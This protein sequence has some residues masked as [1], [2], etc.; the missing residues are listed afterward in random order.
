MTGILIDDIKYIFITY[1]K[2]L[3]SKSLEDN[4][5]FTLRDIFWNGNFNDSCCANHFI[6]LLTN[7]IYFEEQDENFNYSSLLYEYNSDYTQNLYNWLTSLTGYN[8]TSKVYERKDNLFRFQKIE[9][10]EEGEEIDMSEYMKYDDWLE[11]LQEL[12]KK[13]EEQLEKH[14]IWEEAL[15]RDCYRPAELTRIKKVKT[16]YKD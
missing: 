8:N 7:G 13:L 1:D 16:I 9:Y 2:S 11:Q 12:M 4:V 3:K 14:R 15:D 6:N 5:Y 10:L